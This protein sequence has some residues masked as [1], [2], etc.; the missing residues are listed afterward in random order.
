MQ[1]RPCTRCV[2]RNI[3]H[4]CHDEPREPMKRAK[5]EQGHMH[6]EDESLLKPEEPLY[7]KTD[8]GFDQQHPEPLL[9]RGNEVPV[10]LKGTS[11]VHQSNS[12]VPQSVSVSTVS[13]PAS[14]SRDQQ[15]ELRITMEELILLTFMSFGL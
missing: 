5:L 14:G 13:L 2:K 4:L 7:N 15:C 8:S 10:S 6:G 9:L 12:H 1:E 11:T 3:G